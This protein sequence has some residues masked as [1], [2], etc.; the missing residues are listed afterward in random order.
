MLK[1]AAARTFAV[2]FVGTLECFSFGGTMPFESPTQCS[3]SRSEFRSEDMFVCTLC[4]R[5]F[6][7][8]YYFYSL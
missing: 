8:S 4:E 7:L 6:L 5:R 1:S 3:R 2:A